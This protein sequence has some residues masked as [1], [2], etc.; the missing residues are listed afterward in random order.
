MLPHPLTNFE[1]QKYYQNES[2]FDSV[3]ARNNLPKI[4]DGTYLINL[5]ECKSIITHSIGFYV[6][7]KN[8]I[9]S[10]GRK[11]NKNVTTNTCRMQAQNS[12][13]CGYFCIGFIDFR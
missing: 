2:K 9:D 10:F 12:I 8:H 5:D 6:N 7:G 4:Q 3:F 11:K 1:I 13:M